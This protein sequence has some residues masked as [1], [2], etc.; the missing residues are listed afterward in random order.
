[1]DKNRHDET[2]APAETPDPNHENKTV[3][4]DAPSGV[5]PFAHDDDEEQSDEQGK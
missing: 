1:M 4:E 2:V 3:P 5:I